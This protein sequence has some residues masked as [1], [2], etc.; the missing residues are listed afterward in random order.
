MSDNNATCL[1]DGTKT[2]KCERCDVTDTIADEGSAKGHSFT[3]YVNDGNATCTGNGTKTAKCDRCD[4]TDT[5]EIPNSALGHST[6]IVGAKEPTDYENGY[7]GDEVCTVCGQ[8]I[9][10]GK[11]ISLTGDVC[12]WCGEV[13]NDGTFIGFWTE[14]FHDFFYIVHRLMF[15]WKD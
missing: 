3:N 5:V 13:H 7:T 12:L 9:K 8:T 14:F 2:A 15:W 11:V 1:A 6:V 10:K 4:V